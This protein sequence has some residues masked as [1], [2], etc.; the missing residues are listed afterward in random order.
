M[1][2]T[3]ELI[4]D[5]ILCELCGVFISEEGCGYPRSC[6]DCEED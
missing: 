2:E 3:T 6:E 1:G 4:L 5:G